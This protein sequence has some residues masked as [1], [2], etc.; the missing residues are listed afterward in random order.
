VASTF[1][2]WPSEARSFKLVIAAQSLHW[3]A[4]EVRF[5]KAADV[6]T[7]DGMLAVFGN[8]PV[9]LDEALWAEFRRIYRQHLG[10]TIGAPPEAW[11]LPA[12]PITAEFEGSGRFA[13]IMHKS[14]PW[15]RAFTAADYV[16][17]LRTRSD[18]QLIPPE[19]R[20]ALLAAIA[21]TIAAHDGGFEMRYE[22]HL[23]M[24]RSA[25]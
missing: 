8:V 14:Y 12:G 19:P 15:N 3:I 21:A 10:I 4:P 16:E 22:T 9:G 23:Y 2:A 13:A 5:A 11:Y 25:S 20:E 17:F 24:A 6:L 18:H 7:P 1:E